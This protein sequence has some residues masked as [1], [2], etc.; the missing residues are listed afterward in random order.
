M[1]ILVLKRQKHYRRPY[2]NWLVSWK[3]SYFVEIKED[4]DNRV[5]DGLGHY[6]TQARKWARDYARREGLIYQEEF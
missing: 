4:K 6:K 5:I 1:G 2:N 3:W